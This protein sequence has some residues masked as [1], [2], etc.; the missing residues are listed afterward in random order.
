M[1]SKKKVLQEESS[2]SEEDDDEPEEE[3]NED[4]DTNDIQSTNSYSSA[5]RTIDWGLR[6]HPDYQEDY[7]IETVGL[8]FTQWVKIK[9]FLQR[10]PF[11]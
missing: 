11:K 2:S 8:Q 1:N 9:I 10:L 3:E 7:W 5:L 4:I 6:S